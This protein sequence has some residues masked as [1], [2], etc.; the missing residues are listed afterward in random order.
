MT[1]ICDAVTLMGV[2]GGPAVRPG[3]SMPNSNLVELGGKRI[4]VDAGLGAVVGLM[5]AGVN[6]TELD[7]IAITHLHSDHYLELG[8]LLHTA[9]CG[10]LRTPITIIGPSDLVTWWQGFCLSMS[11]DIDLRIRDEGRPDLRDL[12]TLVPLTDGDVANPW[13]LS[14]RA[15]R[16][17]HPP[18]HDSFALR[19]AS[20][21]K[22]VVISGDTAPM[23]EM[24]AFAKDADVLVHEAML[25][26]GVDAIV[27]KA[28]NGDDRLRAHILRSHSAA[29][30][31]AQIAA[32]AKV[33][34]LAL[35]HLIPNDIPGFDW[36]HWQAE[37]APHFAGTWHLGQDGLRIEL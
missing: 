7:G 29:G 5:R 1:K 35:T 27:A 16:N 18:I 19:F 34:Q 10:G 37:I 33:G 22:S 23:P 17:V 21:D 9:W 6:L 24:I 3:S 13:G 4:L 15:M 8:P 28:G 31:V 11:F 2:K 14:M 32:R 30:E 25:L 12:V 36:S 20:G 26:D